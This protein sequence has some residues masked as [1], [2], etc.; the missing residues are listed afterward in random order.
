[1]LHRSNSSRDHQSQCEREKH[2]SEWTRSTLER[3]RVE[4]HSSPK[5]CLRIMKVLNNLKPNGQDL[6]AFA[7]LRQES[8]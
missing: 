2:R 5:K 3:V 4:G 8:D 7:I 1:M 6:P